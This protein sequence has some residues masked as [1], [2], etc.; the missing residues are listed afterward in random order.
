MKILQHISPFLA[1]LTPLFVAL[2]A[3]GA[4]FAPGAFDWVRYAQTSVLGVIML[5]MVMILKAQDSCI[6]V[7][8]CPGATIGEG[9]AIAAG[10][11]TKVVKK[12]RTGA[13][14]N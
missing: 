2:A 3:A 8:T 5:T 9:A 1:K 4:Y 13:N 11:P 14:E 7:G 6:L 10:V 12:C